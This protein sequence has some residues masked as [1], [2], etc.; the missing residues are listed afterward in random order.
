MKKRLIAGLIFII[1]I[2]LFIFNNSGIDSPFTGNII[3]DLFIKPSEVMDFAGV[4]F[5]ELLFEVT[6]DSPQNITYNFES[7]EDPLIDLN[8]SLLREASSW[9]YTLKDIKNDLI[10]NDSVIFTPNGTIRAVRWSNQLIVYAN[11]SVGNIFNNSVV[12]YVN[13][14]NS[15][16][17]IENFSSQIYACEAEFLSYKF[18]ISDVD[19]DTLDVGLTPQYPDNP[20][21]IRF[22][23]TINS[24]VDEYEIYSGTLNKSDAGG[25]GNGSK[26]Y[27]VN[28]SASDD[29]NETCCSDAVGSNI[30]V[31]ETNNA[32]VIENIGVQTVWIVG[33][34]TTFNY[35]VQVEDIEDGDQDS[36][37]L[38]LN[39]SFSG[40]ALFNVS[41]NGV[42]GYSS[43][44]SHLGVHNV[45]ICA[46]DLGL[47]NPHENIS[48]CD[49]DGGNQSSCELFSL[50]VTNANRAPIITS[51]FPVSL[52]LTVSE[53][54]TTVFNISSYDADGTITDTYWYLDD[55]LTEYDSA[56]LIANF[57]YT[58]PSN[59]AGDHNLTVTVTDGNLSSSLVWNIT[60]LNV[61]TPS[62]S[63]GGGGGGG[64]GGGKS[65]I[66]KWG[67][68]TWRECESN[69]SMF[70]TKLIETI[71]SNC[72]LFGWEGS[73]CGYQ[74]R[75]CKD[76]NNCNLT[77]K[78]PSTLRICNY[79]I[80]PDC[81]DGIK[82]CHNNSCEVLVDCG[83]P[84]LPC[85]TCSDGILN[86]GEEKIDCGGPCRICFEIP[87][88]I[89]GVSQNF[90]IW[91]LIILLIIV[92]YLLYKYYKNKMY[93][94]GLIRRT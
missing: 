47:T 11:D 39:I 57:T 89:E 62:S 44:S 55:L 29:N 10:I 90:L 41:S 9:W 37:N 22:F 36:G 49:Q 69:Y 1:L 8:V 33:A 52:S 88:E 35:T 68:R 27:G 16:P 63:S 28:V 61:E 45:S 94:R 15:A 65:C 31:I 19:E 23:S 17:V 59:S 66:Q 18:N 5:I 58:W 21:Y 81:F 86:Q 20:F 48:L 71:Q 7:G 3:L 42:I 6:I 46:I 53:G 75:D 85:P 70:S 92:T 87:L 84:C 14:A 4:V 32:P 64:G 67:C 12:F 74:R 26:I 51:N 91:L 54:D 79:I 77:S 56:S 60:V 80:D 38:T 78:Q 34:N 76:L 83:G 72:T 30:T 73:S 43:N 50:T 25:S 93:F 82:N 40:D 24:T 13:L 2:S